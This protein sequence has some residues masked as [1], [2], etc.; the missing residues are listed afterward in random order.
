[1]TAVVPA[2]SVGSVV[3]VV[4]PAARRG[5]TRITDRVLT[6]VVGR[7]AGEAAGTA[8]LDRSVLGVRVGGRVAARAR[9]VVDGDR[10]TARVSTS[11]EYPAPVRQ[12]ARRIRELVTA[13]VFEMTGM[14]VERVDVEVAAFD[15]PDAADARDGRRR[16]A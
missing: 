11:V 12:V 4:P 8:G 10:V 14:T 1:M 3:P 2:G 6:R 13:R 16:I 5:T 9:V 7:A 15:R